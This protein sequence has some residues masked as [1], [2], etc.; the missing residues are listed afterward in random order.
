MKKIIGLMILTVLF[1]IAVFA[2]IRLPDTPKRT[3]TPATTPQTGEKDAQMIIQISNEVTEPTLVI[4]KSLIGQ[5]PAA[6]SAKLGIG[7]MQTIVGGLFL[8]L[9]MVF[10]GVLLARGKGNMPKATIGV[11]AV[12]VFG[13]AATIVSANIA[14]PRSVP[15]NK[16]LFSKEMQGYAMSR[17]TVKFKVVDNTYSPD[18][19]LLI[20]P[21]APKTSNK[22]DE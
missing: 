1:S 3:P 11:F 10:G 6:E 17:G 5:M 18:I 14:P 15:L 16:N 20:P 19:R 12:A 9:A 22:G 21:D 7:S 13:F 4:N 8:S 2:D